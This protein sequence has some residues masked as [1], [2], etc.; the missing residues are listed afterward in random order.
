MGRRTVAVALLVVPALGLA[1]LGFAIVATA[2]ERPGGPGL[3]APTHFAIR[4]A[5]AAALGAALGVVVARLGVARV[6]RA[7]P[8]LF[9]IALSATAAVFVRGIGVHAAGASR[10]LHLGPLSGSPAPFLIAATGL[11]V[12]AW[13]GR[14]GAAPRPRLASRPLALALALLAV[15]VLVAEPDFSAAAVALS[16]TFAALAGAGVTGRRLVPAAVVLALAL[17]LGASRFGYVGDRIHGFLSPESDRHGHGFEVLALARAR[18][19]AAAGAAGLGHGPSRR[20]LSSP[21]SDYVFALVGEELGRGGSWAVVGAWAALAAGA[22]LATRSAA[23]GAGPRGGAAACAAA[24]LAPA[25]LHIAVCRG[26]T[27]IVGVTMPFL[28]YD[29]ALTI[30]SGGEVGYLVGMALLRAPTLDVTGGSIA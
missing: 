9:A 23:G 27:P 24:L 5:V 8:A 11:L 13:A 26:W 16:V 19:N 22:V 25:A 17:A 6:F 3:G 1:A 29:P 28:S 14:D 4:Q 18:A 2:G 12:A 15:L 20:H 30:A 21:A 10:W 7:A